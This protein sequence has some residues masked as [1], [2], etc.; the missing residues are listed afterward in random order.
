MVAEGSTIAVG[1]VVEDEDT[2]V[3]EEVLVGRGECSIQ[4][5]VDLGPTLPC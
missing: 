2:A 5:V 4:Q 3:A 1:L